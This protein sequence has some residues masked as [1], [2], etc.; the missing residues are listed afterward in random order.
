MTG[1]TDARCF[2]SGAGLAI[3]PREFNVFPVGVAHLLRQQQRRQKVHYRLKKI[4]TAR[5]VWQAMGWRVFWRMVSHGG[6]LAGEGADF[7]EWKLQPCS[8][9][10][11][12]S[13]SWA[14]N[15]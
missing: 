5:V 7:E 14:R 10:L 2:E 12:V 11:E 6:G 13:F 9:A 15:E 8:I 4:V 1:I 3:V